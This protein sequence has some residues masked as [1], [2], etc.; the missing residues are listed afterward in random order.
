VPELD[1]FISAGQP[2]QAFAAHQLSL[3]PKRGQRVLDR[4]AREPEAS[5]EQFTA[6]WEDMGNPAYRNP[7]PSRPATSS[8]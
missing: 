8:A 7:H 6:R 1:V 2:P 3:E 5:Y 4:V